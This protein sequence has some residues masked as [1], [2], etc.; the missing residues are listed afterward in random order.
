MK[1]KGVSYFVNW[2]VLALAILGNVFYIFLPETPFL[3]LP[4]ELAFPLFVALM[5]LN[6]AREKYFEKNLH[7][8]LLLAFIAQ[9]G[10]FWAFHMPVMFYPLN[11]LFTLSSGV[12]LYQKNWLL[13]SLF[14]FFSEFPLGGFAV[15]A[16]ARK[17][18]REGIVL[19]ATSIF[20][21]GFPPT[22]LL[23]F[24]DQ[25]FLHIAV[26]SLLALLAYRLFLKTNSH[27]STP[28]RLFYALYAIH[29]WILASVNQ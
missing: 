26:A 3:S 13:G 28:W 18:V 17:R 21:A 24:S 1:E 19:L 6:L 22:R 5:G 10:Y 2:F 7:T 8:L 12:L 27:T 9:G 4:N 23:I 15:V 11:I 20:L 29:L 25:P 16:F 14:S